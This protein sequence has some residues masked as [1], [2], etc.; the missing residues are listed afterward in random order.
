MINLL[1]IFLNVSSGIISILVYVTL[2]I[3]LFFML[4][5]TSFQLFVDVHYYIFLML[6]TDSIIRLIIR[7][8]KSFGYRRLVLGVFSILPI[9][10]YHGIHLLPF[11]INIGV[12]QIILLVIAISRIQHLSFL[13]EPLRSNPTQSF[14]GGFILII[15]LGAVF[16]MLPML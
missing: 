13:F 12:Q 4:S 9:L 5:M 2:V 1:R 7:P 8:S 15:L 3:E 10:S 16:L 11:D 6:F 14:V